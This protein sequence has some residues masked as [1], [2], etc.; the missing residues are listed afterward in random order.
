MIRDNNCALGKCSNVLHP[1]YRKFRRL[2]SLAFIVLI[3]FSMVCFSGCADSNAEFKSLQKTCE[4]LKVKVNAASKSL[5]DAVND[6]KNKT[7]QIS[8]EDVEDSS[9]LDN[10]NSLFDE[11][12]N[13][14][15]ST[16]S[17]LADNAND[18]KNSNKELN[19]RLEN[20]K[21]KT[22]QL[23]QASDDVQVSYRKHVLSEAKKIADDAVGKVKDPKV[24]DNLNEA[25][26]NNDID[27]IPD[28]VKAVNESIEAKNKEDEEARKESQK[29]RLPATVRK[30]PTNNVN[31]QPQQQPQQQP[32]TNQGQVSQ[33]YVH[34]G[35]FCSQEG[36]TGVTTK[37]T[38]MVCISRDGDR[39]RWRRG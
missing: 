21:D 18:I 29:K 2:S 19:N 33:N 7:S 9:V 28:A 3:S 8:A 39:P 4:N 23:Q 5:K 6:A 12:K 27:A 38:P 22:K 30:Q 14:D 26:N 10:L 13:E 31:P 37:G 16:I 17:C 25:I 1:K 11:V 34:P 36:A 32:Q 20:Y 35:S 24:I 15:F